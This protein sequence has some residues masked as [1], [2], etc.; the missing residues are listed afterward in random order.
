M[1]STLTSKQGG[2]T[3]SKKFVNFPPAEIFFF[4]EMKTELYQQRFELETRKA[5]HVIIGISSVGSLQM[6]KCIAGSKS[7]LQSYFANLLSLIQTRFLL[8]LMKNFFTQSPSNSS[9]T[10]LRI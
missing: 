5:A 7:L 2:E 4:L 9:H 8:V 1:T 3:D 6:L 10:L